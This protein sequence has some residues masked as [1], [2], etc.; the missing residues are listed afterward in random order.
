[1]IKSTLFIGETVPV[2]TKDKKKSSKEKPLVIETIGEYSKELPKGLEE[3]RAKEF[4]KQT[5][6]VLLNHFGMKYGLSTK[7]LKRSKGF[8]EILN[9]LQRESAGENVIKTKRRKSPK[10]PKSPN[11]SQ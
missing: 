2:I 9:F 7:L 3:H 11:K 10:R 6:C 8:E 5:E 4:A 1:M